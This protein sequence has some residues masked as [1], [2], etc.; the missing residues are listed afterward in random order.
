MR[1]TIGGQRWRVF[2]VS[3]RSKHLVHEDGSR[4]VGRCVY[5]TCSIYLSRDLAPDVLEDTL[6]HELFHATLYVTGA[7]EVY[8]ASHAKE[9]RFVA[10][11][12]PA[13]HRLLKDLGFQFPK[14]A[15]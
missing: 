3:P 7:E 12:T 13:W 4:L 8:G 6:L 11:L 10:A 2:I 1:L 14:R 9:E 5:T 15:A